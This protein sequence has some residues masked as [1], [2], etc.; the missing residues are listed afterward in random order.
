MPLLTNLRQDPF[1]R[2]SINRG[3]SLSTGSPGY[4]NDFFAREFWRFVVARAWRS[5]R[6]TPAGR[7][8][9][10]MDA[11][12]RWIYSARRIPIGQFGDP[13]ADHTLGENAATA[14]D[15]PAL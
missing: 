5:R 1:E 7:T 9:P 3:E 8:P 13:L 2:L 15:P 4:F 6:L 10:G 11:S 12:F 14:R